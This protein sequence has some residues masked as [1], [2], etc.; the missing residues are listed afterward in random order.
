M[1]DLTNLFGVSASSP[2]LESYLERA[3]NKIGLPSIPQP[4]IK[5][6]PDVVYFNYYALGL[7]LLFIP[8]KGLSVTLDHDKLLLDGADIF[9]DKGP[10]YSPFPLLPLELRR[11]D[12]TLFELDS[13]TTGQE[14]VRALGEPA[15][16]GGGTGLSSGSISIWCEWSKLGVMVEFGG[17]EAR[18]PQA[19]ERGKDAAWK[20][21]SFFPPKT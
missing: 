18:G 13:A 17:D 2:Q 16:K 1:S 19:W 5:A 15:R 12:D 20:I 14:F 10:S 11:E 6:Y 4:D 3:A 9:N 21:V 7:C 8:P